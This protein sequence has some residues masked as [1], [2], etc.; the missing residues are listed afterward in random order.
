MNSQ[1]LSILSLTLFLSVL[2]LQA[3]GIDCWLSAY[4]RGVGKPIST[5]QSGQQQNGALCYPTCSSGYYGVGP[6][7]WQSCPSGYSDTGVDCLKPSSYGRGAGY[8]LTQKSKCV[9]EHPQGC[10]K[11]GLL[12]YPK[13]ADG[14][15]NAGCCVCSPKCPSGMTDI[16][17]SCQKKSYG[18]GAGTPLVC[19]VGL[20]EDAALCY[21]PCKSGFSGKGPVCWGSCPS[22]SYQCG[23][24]CLG[25]AAECTTNMLNIGLKAIT[26]VLEIA[27]EAENP[28]GAAISAFN[29][30]SDIA[31]DFNYPV[32]SQ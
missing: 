29:T 25:S 3:Q 2:Q 26:G 17:V 16:G 8:T 13:C 28:V 22:G 19:A 15:S 9:K 20:Q 24:L 5:C 6:V 1:K 18:R 11:Y 30:V 7:C 10:E 14:F 21:T 32:C 12:Y 4:G 31:G 23:A 27:S